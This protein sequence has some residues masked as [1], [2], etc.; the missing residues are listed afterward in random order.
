MALALGGLD[1][2]VRSFG[3]CPVYGW[4]FV[5]PP[6]G[7]WAS[8]RDRVSLDARLDLEPEFPGSVAGSGGTAKNCE[9]R[10]IIMPELEVRPR[11]KP[12]VTGVFMADQRTARPK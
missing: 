6:A 1:A 3:G 2:A 10:L 8:W 12:P 5:D 11:M 7:S 9:E 4:E